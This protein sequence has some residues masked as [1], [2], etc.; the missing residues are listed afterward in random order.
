MSPHGLAIALET[1]A[2][3]IMNFNDR[4]VGTIYNSDSIECGSF[5]EVMVMLLKVGN[6]FL[7]DEKIE[8]FANK[9]NSYTGKSIN[10]IGIETATAIYEDF[11]KLLASI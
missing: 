6:S 8:I 11:N 5:V 1:T 9:Y 10:D 3:R 2:R 4:P 7:I